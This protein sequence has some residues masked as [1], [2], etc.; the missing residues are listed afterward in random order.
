[1][2]FHLQ[3]CTYIA[4]MERQILLTGHARIAWAIAESG[5]TLVQIGEEIG[6]THATLSQ[7]Q[8]GKTVVEKIQA[9][10]L[11][12]F[13]IATNTELRWLLYGE[14]PRRPVSQSSEARRLASA[15]RVMQ[16][17]APWKVEPIVTMVE[18]AAKADG[19]ATPKH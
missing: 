2:Q 8:N 11:L 18:A 10:L 4:R 9:G 3:A 17:Q 13:A 6:C 5:K 15:L 19:T 12:K 7:W 16:E 1:M 14:E